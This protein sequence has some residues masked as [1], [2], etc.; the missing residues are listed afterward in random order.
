MN[1]RHLRK[2]LK[3]RSHKKRSTRQRS[4]RSRR[5]GAATSFPAAYFGVEKAAGPPSVGAGKDILGAGANIVRPA[6]DISGGK[7]RK[8]M[9]K[10][11]GFVP[12]IMGSFTT[13]VSKYIVPIALFAGY[14]L[15]T[16]KHKK[17]HK[18]R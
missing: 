12:S 10:R 14:K 4:N 9:R 7:R 18:R 15:M 6:I 1:K 13:A 16:R 11:G 3:R 5:G 17:S 2:S 8:T